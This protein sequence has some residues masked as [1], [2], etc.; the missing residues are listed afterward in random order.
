VGPGELGGPGSEEDTAS[1]GAAGG[2]GRGLITVS[3]ESGATVVVGTLRIPSAVSTCG[4]CS[5]LHPK[6]AVHSTLTDIRPI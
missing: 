3:A 6:F 4:N 2:L 5:A 1:L